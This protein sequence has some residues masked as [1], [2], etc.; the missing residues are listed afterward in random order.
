VSQRQVWKYPL[1]EDDGDFRLTIPGFS[2]FVSLQVVDGQPVLYFE[3]DP[4]N[5]PLIKQFYGRDTGQA[6]LAEHVHE[7]ALQRCVILGTYQL[8]LKHLGMWS[9]RHIWMQT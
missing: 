4:A 7:G 2:K 3:V 9:V 5:A 6:L 8:W 1:P